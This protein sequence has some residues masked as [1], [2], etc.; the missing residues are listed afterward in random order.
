MKKLGQILH[1]AIIEG[2]ASRRKFGKQDDTDKQRRGLIRIDRC[3]TEQIRS[4]LT[5]KMK[6]CIVVYL[7]HVYSDGAQALVDAIKRDVPQNVISPA[8]NNNGSS[9][10]ALRINIDMKSEL[11]MVVKKLE[12]AIKSVGDYN[13]KSVETLCGNII[14]AVDSVV[15]A[16]DIEN[17]DIK[18]MSNWKEM[19]ERL[20][21]PKVREALLAFQTT[22]AYAQQYGHVLT[23]SNVMQVLSQCPT[24]S[25]VTEASTW[26]KLFKRRVNP[27]AQRIIVK[28]A[29]NGDYMTYLDAA[30]RQIGYK[31]FKDAKKRTNNSA[32]VMGQ[33]RI[34]AGMM[35][36]KK[37]FYYNVVMYDVAD[38][39]PIDPN[40][41]VWTKEIGLSDNLRGVLNNVAAEYDASLNRDDENDTI[42]KAN[43]EKI[44]LARQQEMPNRR[45][46]MEKICERN[47]FGIKV[48]T[49]SFAELDDI[50]FIA[51]AAYMFAKEAAY[52]F[53][54]VRQEDITSLA[55]S[56]AIVVC[57]SSGIDVGLVN[58]V[59]LF[60]PKNITDEEAMNTFTIC[61]SILPKLSSAIRP[62]DIQKL[63][64]ES[65][66]RRNMTGRDGRTMSMER[67]LDIAAKRYGVPGNDENDVERIVKEEVAKTLKRI[68][69][70]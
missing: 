56:C 41:D 45:S 59:R 11:P 70:R 10:V 30:A 63:N 9:K 22:N 68:I 35:S 27:G 26:S 34:N 2:F 24:A 37:R 32:Q 23:P 62:K 64:M 12:G 55:N 1:E 33:I 18:R 40:N 69:V 38:T 44:E 53:G 5:G 61:D 17:A 49:S 65:R 19:L 39:T 6:E 42:L 36:G 50:N 57:Q 15:T 25:F 67:F 14:D 52:K 4:S 8:V 29:D 28:K 58:S 47:Q 46:Q 3:T 20:K 7:S 51:K 13:E 43:R 54:V 31:D 66:E 48:D 21:D 16:K 60:F